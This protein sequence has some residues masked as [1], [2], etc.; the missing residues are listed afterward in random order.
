M[1]ELSRNDQ[2][3]LKFV[4]K[5]ATLSEK[6]SWKRKYNNLQQAI[7]ALEPIREREL[8][9]LAEK[10]PLLDKIEEIRA[11]MVETCVHPLDHLE[12]KDD[13]IIECKF[14]GA[15][16]SVPKTSEE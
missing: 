3:K 7:E 1:E 10:A 16:L 11:A 14:C 6:N 8:A 2:E 9:L 5:F 13:N 15:R 4:A 12:M